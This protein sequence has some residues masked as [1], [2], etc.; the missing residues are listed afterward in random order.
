MGNLFSILLILGPAIV[1]LVSA[2][3]LLQTIRKHQTELERL[4]QEKSQQ[5]QELANDET[6]QE[7]PV[8]DTAPPA[9]SLNSTIIGAALFLSILLLTFSGISISSQL[10]MA[11]TK[12]DELSASNQELNDK[13][14]ELKSENTILANEID[15]YNHSVASPLEKL[16]VRNMVEGQ[17][18]VAFGWEPRS[19]EMELEIIT[20]DGETLSRALPKAENG[21]RYTSDIKRR[22][23]TIWWPNQATPK[24][25]HRVIIRHVSGDP[26]NIG[27]KIG[28]NNTVQ[29]YEDVLSANEGILELDVEV[30]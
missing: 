7:E 10:G 13:V 27:I 6:A 29:E 24:G 17:L 26:A 8:I 19:A 18:Q 11:H 23:Q 5:Y 4:N 2:F 9:N 1:A 28:M 30:P 16:S 20:P 15:D 22:T 25:T 12:Y 21:G 14:K 3:L